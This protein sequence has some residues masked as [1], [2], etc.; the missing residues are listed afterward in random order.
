MTE[1]GAQEPKTGQPET[2]EN[3]VASR[4]RSTI[5]FPYMNLDVVVPLPKAVYAWGARTCERGQLAGQLKM[6][7]DGGQFRQKLQN[8]RTYGLLNYSGQS[9]ELTEVG[10][11]LCDPA[12][13]KEA[14]V[15]AFLSV[16]LFEQVYERLRDHPL[17]PDAAIQ[18]QMIEMGVA[19]KQAQRARRAFKSSAR[20]A[21]FFEIASDRLVRPHTSGSNGQF[22]KDDSGT[23]EVN[24]HSGGGDEPPRGGIHPLVQAL[25]AEM[26]EA[27]TRWEKD[28]CVTWLKMMLLSLGMIYENR[29]ELQE[30]EITVSD[31]LV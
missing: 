9:V 14:L 19:P 29:N 13:E 23:K 22:G 21:G 17:P 16:P 31:D 25:L 12:T 27:G 30:I 26:P 7:P 8:A 11:R 10:V 2:A 3:E 28:H 6:A 18:R 15:Q 20:T 24:Q 1:N 4:E 5:L